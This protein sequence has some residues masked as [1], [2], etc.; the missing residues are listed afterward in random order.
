MN[1]IKKLQNQSEKKRKLILWSIIIILSLFLG[2]FWINSS[3]KSLKNVSNIN[4]FSGINI[5]EIEE[6]I[7]E[8]QKIDFS[9]MTEEE[10]EEIKR[11]L[12]RLEKE[13]EEAASSIEE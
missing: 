9:F 3:Y 1:F 5:S 12:E 10:I 7:K 2:G 11:D 6:E 4:I 8:I 13:L